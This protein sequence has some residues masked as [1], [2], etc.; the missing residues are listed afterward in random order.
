MRWLSRSNRN[1]RR[2]PT[3]GLSPIIHLES[4]VEQTAL[5][6]NP[7]AM[8]YQR[9][10]SELAPTV[11]LRSAAEYHPRPIESTR[12][13]PAFN[14]LSTRVERTLFAIARLPP[15]AMEMQSYRSQFQLDF[16]KEFAI[17][18]RSVD[19][20]TN[21]HASNFNRTGNQFHYF[22]FVKQVKSKGKELYH[23]VARHMSSLGMKSADIFGLSIRIGKFSLILFTRTL[24]A[25]SRSA[26]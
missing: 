1:W 25:I 18:K 11:A 9:V 15:L 24:S 22:W 16:Q 10:E 3:T 20:M 2:T 21:A 4:S 17:N 8:E 6:Q 14:P 13:Q 12:S 19:V 26:F 23:A 5:T 7:I